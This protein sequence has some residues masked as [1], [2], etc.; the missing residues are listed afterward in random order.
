M[1]GMQAIIAGLFFGAIGFGAFSYG[2]KMSYWKPLAI[3]LA[4]MTY[5]YFVAGNNYL[6]WGIGAGLLALLWRHHDE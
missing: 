1:F 4:L 3:G 5:P 2:R 6:L